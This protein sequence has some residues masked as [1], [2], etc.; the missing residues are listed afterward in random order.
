MIRYVDEDGVVLTREQYRAGKGRGRVVVETTEFEPSIVDESALADTDLNQLVRRWT[1]GEAVPQFAPMQFGDL[2]EPISFQEMQQRLLV[3]ESLFY[4]MPADVRS[5][6]GNSP[7]AFADA[8][9]DPT[10]VGEMQDLGLLKKPDEAV[11]S[12][13]AAPA[14]PAV[15]PPEGAGSGGP[16]A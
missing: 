13:E 15:T 1:R 16:T 6:F 14:K 9:V 3:V 11:P 4:S 10:R 12:G 2:S 5:V 7:S 8:M